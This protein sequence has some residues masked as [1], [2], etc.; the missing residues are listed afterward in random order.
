[1]AGNDTPTD[2]LIDRICA[3]ARQHVARQE[4]LSKA[5]F[6]RVNY[7]RLA[8]EKAHDDRLTYK[9]L[10]ESI[11]IETGHRFTEA[12]LRKCMHH[13]AKKN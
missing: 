9:A 11:S 7:A 1:M 8:A 6:V 4:K 12:Y 2:N 3:R 5:R 10:A 13:A